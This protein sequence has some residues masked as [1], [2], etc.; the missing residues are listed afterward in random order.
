MQ[1]S[2]RVCVVTLVRGMVIRLRKSIRLKAHWSI[3]LRLHE[4][5][6]IG[7]GLDCVNTEY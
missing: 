6:F 4:Y 1:R 7:D 5:D 3:S 2:R